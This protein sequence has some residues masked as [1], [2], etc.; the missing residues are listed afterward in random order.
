MDREQKDGCP[1]ELKMCKKHREIQPAVR[2]SRKEITVRSMTDV[3][4]L[5]N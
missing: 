1:R 4:S 3:R 5:H 2:S